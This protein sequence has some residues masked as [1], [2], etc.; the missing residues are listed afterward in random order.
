MTSHPKCTD[1]LLPKGRSAE[2]RK[3]PVLCC[4]LKLAVAGIVALAAST[5]ILLLFCV[6]LPNVYIPQGREL[7]VI[8]KVKDA[9]VKLRTVDHEVV[10]NW[11]FD[12]RKDAEDEDAESLLD[13]QNG[14]LSRFSARGAYNRALGKYKNRHILIGDI[15]GQS[16][17]LRE[18]LRKIKYN[19]AHDNLVV[20]GDFISKGRDSIGVLEELIAA[21]AQ[22]VIGNHEYDVLRYYTHFHRLK[23]PQF[24]NAKGDKTHSVASKGK[25]LK[26]EFQLA[27]KLQ[28]NHIK[29]INSCAVMYKLGKVPVHSKNTDSSYTTGQ[30][31]AVHAGLQWDLT[32]D[33]DGQDSLLCISMR[34]YLGPFYNETTDDPS[35]HN[36]VSWSKIWNKKHKNGDVDDKYV[37]YYGHDARRGLKLKQWSKGLDTGCVKG[38]HLTAM[39]IWKEK[40]AQGALYR[41]RVVLVSCAVP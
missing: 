10:Q 25:E 27:R 3:R 28:P 22:C 30:G 41:E 38:N 15:H 23:D 34:S 7:I 13:E 32:A 17:E 18:L 21:N 8:Q 1:P 36:A 14:V 12:Q 31:V 2:K 6:Y 4:R 35:E 16:Q 37:V 20:L 26:P 39:V 11:G 29:Y 5:A 9:G 19:K 24:V 40:T 33:L